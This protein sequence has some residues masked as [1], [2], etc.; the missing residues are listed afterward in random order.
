MTTKEIMQFQDVTFAYE[1]GKVVLNKVNLQLFEGKTYA[2]VGPTGGGKT[3]TA[4]LMARLYD[5]T[6]GK[7]EFENQDIRCFSAQEL[8]K[9]IGFI[10][11]EPFL[12]SGTVG[13]NLRYGNAEISQVEDATLEKNLQ[14]LGS[15]KMI[16]MFENALQTEV[17]ANS[18][19]ISLGQKQLISFMRTMLRKPKF[20]IL[21]EATANIDTITESLLEEIIGRLPKTTTKVII[22]H[23]LST[24]K[25]ADQIFFINSGRVQP[26]A[27]FEDAIG[28]IEGGS[29]KT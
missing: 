2:L 13:D 8:A 23:R 9:S 16:S 10:L 14:D 4:S 7:V 6:S 19:N 18:E 20:L 17:S 21:D 11:Q 22:A 25:D 15:E 27:N 28:L 1:G 26:A 3:T 12:F 24:I 5:P 29:K